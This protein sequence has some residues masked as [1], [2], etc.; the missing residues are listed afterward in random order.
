MGVGGLLRKVMGVAVIQAVPG[1]LLATVLTGL[2]SRAMFSGVRWWG[3]WLLGSVMSATDPVAVVAVLATLGA[4]KHL[5]HSI[6]GESL[7]NDGSAV[8][9]FTI[10]RTMLDSPENQLSV[11]EMLGKFMRLGFG[12]VAWGLFA[13]YVAFVWCR[14]TMHFSVIDVSVL[15][16]SVWLTFYVGEHTLGVSGVLGV[17]CFGLVLSRMA[18]HAMSGD[19]LHSTHVVFGQI[20]HFAE[21]H[22]FVLAGLIIEQRFF[23]QTESTLDFSF[24]LP[25]AA[26]NYVAVHA[27]RLVVITTFSPIFDRMGYGITW[28]ESAMMVFA[29]LRGAVSLAMALLADMDPNVTQHEKDIIVFHVAMIVALTVVVNGTTAGVLYKKLDMY[30]MNAFRPEL[31]ARGLQILSEEVDSLLEDIS[32]HWFH[33][34]ADVDTLRR[35]LPDFSLAKIHLGE[36]QVA[37]QESIFEMLFGFEGYVRTKLG[38]W[39]RAKTQIAAQQLQRSQQ[40]VFPA[41][42]RADVAVAPGHGHGHG[43]HEHANLGHSHHSH[44]HVDCSVLPK[45]TLTKTMS[46]PSHVHEFKS[47]S[48]VSAAT[49]PS[50]SSHHSAD[51]PHIWVGRIPL[52]SATVPCVEEL[53]KPFG[54]VADVSIKV[55]RAGRDTA[56][57]GY[58]HFDGSD[59]EVEE[60][61]AAAMAQPLCLMDD[62]A[63]ACQVEVR[64]AV[65]ARVGDDSLTIWNTVAARGRRRLDISKTHMVSANDAQAERLLY[66]IVYVILMHPMP[67]L[68]PAMLPVCLLPAG[69]TVSHS[70]SQAMLQLRRFTA[71][72][73]RYREMAEHKLIGLRTLDRLD[74]ALKKG[75]DILVQMRGQGEHEKEVVDLVRGQSVCT[76]QEWPDP[77]YHAWF[78]NKSLEKRYKFSFKSFRRSFKSFRR[79]DSNDPDSSHLHDDVN[80]DSLKSVKNFVESKCADSSMSVLYHKNVEDLMLCAE[81]AWAV[82]GACDS[83]T[84]TRTH[85]RTHAHTHTQAVVPH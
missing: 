29:G 76:R 12:G 80:S 14:Y 47:E 35:L 61:I 74:E 65:R 21:T 17:V 51:D 24:H 58:V 50:A 60:A 32:H 82:R 40:L 48:P 62:S 78:D 15:L 25:M 23:G 33:R 43:H 46:A 77:L 54:T 38:G 2:V 57:W 72:H 36:V 84:H 55:R 83:C 68:H 8:V 71:V 81:M 49:D 41:F 34:P 6:E 13:G 67:C 31:C 1:V 73:A 9:I 64:R 7:F 79:N 39:S 59:A 16:L 69:Q 63:Q 20:S 37:K 18:P 66:E 28:K 52:Y 26:V 44:A 75:Q 11:P 4:P 70:L 27:V 19:V 42:Q 85:T 3:C 56:S 5:S 10:A 53:M 30:P 45:Q 22:I